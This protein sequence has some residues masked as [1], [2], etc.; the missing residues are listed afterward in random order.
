MYLQRLCV[1]KAVRNE[2]LM[3]AYELIISAVLGPEY[4]IPDPGTLESIIDDSSFLTPYLIFHTFSSDP[5]SELYALSNRAKKGPKLLSL[6][7]G[8]G[9]I[10][11]A[12]DLIDKARDKGKWLLL[13]NLHLCQSFLPNLEDAENRPC[14]VFR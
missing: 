5:V 6:S 8:L 3:Q 4:L 9:K 10:G 14:L 7:L 1:I 13:Q 2:R 12:L 11:T